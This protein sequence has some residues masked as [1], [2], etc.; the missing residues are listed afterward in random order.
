MKRSLFSCLAAL[1]L[2]GSAS[3][4]QVGLP[5]ERPELSRLE[6]M[7]NDRPMGLAGFDFTAPEYFTSLG[8]NA[9]GAAS[10]VVSWGAADF[11]GIENPELAGRLFTLGVAVGKELTSIEGAWQRADQFGIPVRDVFVDIGMDVVETI[12]T[13]Y[14]LVP[15]TKQLGAR[16]AALAA[17]AQFVLQ[18]AIVPYRDLR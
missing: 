16:G 6:M 4:Q 2:A 13:P 7:F 10:Y 15:L 9:L 8:H 14:V 18:Y 17:V 3:A 5:F 11:V 1:L 12:W